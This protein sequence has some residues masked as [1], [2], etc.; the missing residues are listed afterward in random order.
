MKFD[1]AWKGKTYNCEW[2][3]NTDFENLDNVKGVA[4][5]IFDNNKNLCVVRLKSKGYWTLIG[6]GVEKQDKNYEETLIRE[7]LEEAD[8]DIKDIQRLGYIT[9]HYQGKEKDK[10]LRFIARVNKINPLTIDPAEN[11]INE[12]EFINP[13]DFEEYTQWGENG[14]FQLNK[15]LEKLNQEK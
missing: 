1:I 12:V 2:C 9:I 14:I 13:K 3:D 11:D 10:Q 7:A 6:G 5:F 4:A 8:L 15:A